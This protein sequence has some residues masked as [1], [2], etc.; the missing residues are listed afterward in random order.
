MTLRLALAAAA[1]L[2]LSGCASNC[3]QACILG[4]GPGSAAFNAV[5]DSADRADAC[6][7][8]QFS[9]VTGQRLKPAGHTAPDFCKHRNNNQTRITDRNGH[10][11]GYIR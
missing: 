8:A 4:F 9:S 3:T 6:Q 1:L 7:T 5:A 10:T 11:V 2:A